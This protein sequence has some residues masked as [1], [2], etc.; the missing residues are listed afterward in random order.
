MYMF[1]KRWN[2]F[3]RR[4]SVLLAPRYN[5]CP[6]SDRIIK[7]I[8]TLEKFYD[9]L[10]VS[11][12][13]LSLLTSN[14]VF[15]NFSLFPCWYDYFLWS[16]WNSSLIRDLSFSV[17]AKSKEKKE[18]KRERKKKADWKEILSISKSDWNKRINGLVMVCKRFLT[19][20]VINLINSSLSEQFHSEHFISL[21]SSLP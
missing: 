19:E 16:K 7:A 2:F 8:I 4:L 20:V 17:C 9:V 12:R 14:S 3:S 10:S 21:L 5:R 1:R 18:R 13:L 11:L 6:R 15:N